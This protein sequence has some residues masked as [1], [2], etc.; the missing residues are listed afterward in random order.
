MESGNGKFNQWKIESGNEKF[1]QWK[2]EFGNIEVLLNIFKT[3]LKCVNFD[4]NFWGGCG[5]LNNFCGYSENSGIF[6][7]NLE[8]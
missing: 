4:S 6:E 8:I 5:N 3:F 1:N 2:I 7:G